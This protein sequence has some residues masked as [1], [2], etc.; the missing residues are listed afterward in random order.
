MIFM[1]KVTVEK[2][3]LFPLTQLTGISDLAM[4]E[5]KHGKKESV[6]PLG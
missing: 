3:I 5:G 2:I 4:S 1:I 6:E